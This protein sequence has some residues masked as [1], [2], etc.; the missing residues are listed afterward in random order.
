MVYKRAME[1]RL[2]MLEQLQWRLRRM[3][4]LRV[5]ERASSQKGDRRLTEI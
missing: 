4:V 1:F 5:S 2:V 3:I